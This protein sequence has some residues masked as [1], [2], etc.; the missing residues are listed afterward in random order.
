MNRRTDVHVNRCTDLHVKTRKA[1]AQ[2]RRDSPELHTHIALLEDPDETVTRLLLIVEQER[3]AA[4]EE[5]P[6]ESTYV[7]AG[8]PS[9][10]VEPLNC[11]NVPAGHFS[12]TAPSLEYSPGTHSAQP[13][14]TQ[15]H[16]SITGKVTQRSHRTLGRNLSTRSC[17]NNL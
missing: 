14:A 1:G 16:K 13:E 7:P 10:S 12:H 2:R 5:E 6:M 11:A 17:A 4:D 15:V 9:H 3:Q 8:Q